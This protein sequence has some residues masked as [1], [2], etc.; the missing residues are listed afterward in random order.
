MRR[1]D[2]MALFGSTAIVWPLAAR[3]QQPANVPVIGWLVF[4]AGEGG[5]DAFRQGLGELGYV[6]RRDRS[7]G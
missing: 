7:H 4:E 3:G 5:L 1:R 2:L 6:L